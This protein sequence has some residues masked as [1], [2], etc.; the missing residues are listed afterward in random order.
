MSITPDRKQELIQE[1]RINEKDSGSAQV[2]VA[3]LTERIRNI[4]EHLKSNKKDFASQ[5]GLM[6]MVGHRSTLL[7]YLASRNR[8]EYAQLIQSLGL[9]K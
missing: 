1:Y 9:R 6:K 5:R 3:I 2:Q 8:A 4:T 7:K